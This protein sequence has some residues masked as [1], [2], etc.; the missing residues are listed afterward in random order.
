MFTYRRSIVTWQIAK[1]LAYK[2]NIIQFDSLVLIQLCKD[3]T[4]THTITNNEINI[5]VLLFIQMLYA[6]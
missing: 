5:L 3:Y 4:H 1:V 6:V 2:G